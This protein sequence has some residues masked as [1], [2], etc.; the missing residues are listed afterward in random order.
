MLPALQLTLYPWDRYSLALCLP[1]VQ[2]NC[3]LS[4]TWQHFKYLKTAPCH[5]SPRP[6]EPPGLASPGQHTQFLQPLSIWLS[7]HPSYSPLEAFLVCQ[8]PLKTHWQQE[9]HPRPEAEQVSQWPTCRSVWW[10]WYHPTPRAPCSLE[11][12]CQMVDRR[13]RFLLSGFFP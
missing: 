4:S 5:P 10:G 2:H 3:N 1:S 13:L 6:H 9:P 12:L 11:Q 7:F 8:Q